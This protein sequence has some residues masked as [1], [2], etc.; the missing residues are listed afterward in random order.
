MMKVLSEGIAKRCL[1]AFDR[2]PWW[3]KILIILFGVT[4]GLTLLCPWIAW[5]ILSLFRRHK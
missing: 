3:G 5:K 1:I 4:L 2:A